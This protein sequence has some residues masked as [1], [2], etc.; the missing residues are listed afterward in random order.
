[1]R[2]WSLDV[3]VPEVTA[4]S[5]EDALKN[6]PYGCCVYAC[7]NDVVDNQ[8][9][10]M[11]FEN[12]ATASMT[13]T[14]FTPHSGR[15]TRIF[16]TL[17]ELDTDSVNFRITHFLDDSIREFDTGVNNDGG[18]LSAH[19]RGDF[20]LMDAFVQAVAENDPSKILSGIDETLESHLM[21]F[22]AEESRKT[23]KVCQPDFCA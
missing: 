4:D 10:N 19:G 18:I 13:M 3:L 6:G 14:A 1:M 21:V 16:G 12:G 11:I 15:R 17:G 22:A 5:L 20:G 9:V 2:G 7:D 23:G 8:V